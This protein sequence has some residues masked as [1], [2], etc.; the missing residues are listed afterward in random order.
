MA[1][2]FLGPLTAQADEIDRYVA[3]QIRALHIPGLSLAVV[4]DGK[5]IK[6]QGY[7]LVDLE[8]NAPATK[9]TVYE[10]G[11]I[12]KQFTAAAVMLL[13]EEGRLELSDTISKYFPD[14]PESWRPITIQ[15]LLTHTSGIQNHVAVPGYLKVFKTNLS[16]DESPSR[17]ELLKMF[18]ALPL[19]FQPGET[20]A[21]DNTG[22]YLLGIIIE[23]TS[24]KSYWEFLH[25]RVFK[26]LEMKAT[27]NTDMR[28]I[29]RNRASGYAWVKDRYENRPVLA[30]FIAFSA[31]SLLSTVEDMVKW[32]AALT[33]GKL[34]RQAALERIWAP[35]RTN[36]GATPPFDYGFAWFIH[37]YR[38][39]RIVQHSGGTPGFS[40]TYYRF[41]DD[42]LSII[43][44][45]NHSDR[46]LDQLAVDIAGMYI[47]GLK[48]PDGRT[49]P[50]PELSSRLKALTADLLAGKANPEAFAPAMRIFLNTASGRSWYQWFAEH[51]EL[52]SFT[53]SESEEVGES[54]VLRYK[55]GLGGNSYWCSVKLNSDDRIAQVHLW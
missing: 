17:D 32:D 35:V 36:D 18:F 16:W 8:L 50:H 20:W 24:G 29:V 45:T 1:F 5:L 7:G 34:L 51:G 21:Y 2:A 42:K 28:P 48:R 38:G 25:D 23:K 43:I 53:F 31:G 19:E 22:Y 44:L 14:A 6:A 39:R 11:S 13:V 46:V 30:P 12:S 26:P 55:I 4:R 9:A 37:A 27:R 47:P 10:I 15:H 3:A 54:R 49:D 41:L 40:S 52:T 33:S